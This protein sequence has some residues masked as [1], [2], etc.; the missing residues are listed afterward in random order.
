MLHQESVELF[1]LKVQTLKQTKLARLAES[2][3]RDTEGPLPVVGARL[4]REAVNAALNRIEKMKK[5][6]VKLPSL[7]CSASFVF[8]SD[9]VV[10][11]THLLELSPF[12]ESKNAFKAFSLNTL[13]YGITVV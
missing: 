9:C 13:S 6:M 4:L 1:S 12:I 10:T 8:S 7:A 5:Q 3:G 2:L 11:P